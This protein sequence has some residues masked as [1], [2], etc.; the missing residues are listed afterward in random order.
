MLDDVRVKAVTDEVLIHLVLPP[1]TYKGREKKQEIIKECVDL[2]RQ[3]QDKEQEAF[4][5]AEILMFTDKIISK[6]IQKYIE[7]V[8]EMT[9]VGKML[10]DKI[11]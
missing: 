2:A 5:L 11:K 1:S 10:I 7:E 3:L 9:Q 6:E 8:L 4:A